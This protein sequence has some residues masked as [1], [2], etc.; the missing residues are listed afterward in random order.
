MSKKPKKISPRPRVRNSAPLSTGE[1]CYVH[2]VR[3]PNEEHY[4][5]QRHG[6]CIICATILWELANVG[7]EFDYRGARVVMRLE[8]DQS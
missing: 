5:E 7:M 2:G 8:V 6:I 4:D 1:R 3:D